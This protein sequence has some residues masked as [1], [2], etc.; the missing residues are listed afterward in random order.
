MPGSGRS[1][2]LTNLVN[3]TAT[4]PP[5]LGSNLTVQGPSNGFFAMKFEALLSLWGGCVEALSRKTTKIE[6]YGDK[7]TGTVVRPVSWEYA[8]A[9]L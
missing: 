4:G 5:H 9:K 8:E 1:I 6:P 2:Q 3:S 7:R